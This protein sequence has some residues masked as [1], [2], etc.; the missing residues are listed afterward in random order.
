MAALVTILA[1]FFMPRDDESDPMMVCVPAPFYMLVA[2]VFVEL[3]KPMQHADVMLDPNTSRMLNAQAALQSFAWTENGRQDK[4]KARTANGSTALA[5]EPVFS[6]ETA[7]RPS[8]SYCC[9]L[10]RSVWQSQSLCNVCSGEAAL[11]VYTSVRV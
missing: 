4:V 10:N 2:A 7:V 11:L 9:C 1:Y 8:W 3:L 6:F 5:K